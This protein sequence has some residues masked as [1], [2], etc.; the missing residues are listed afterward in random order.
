[1]QNQGNFMKA[2]ATALLVTL[3][4]F[5]GGCGTDQTEAQQEASGIWQANLSG[6][7][8]GFSFITQFTINGN[9]ALTITNFQFINNESCFPFSDG[10]NNATPAG[11]LTNLTYNAGNQIV[12]GNFSFTI[13]QNGNTLTLTST[14]VN[15]TLNGTSLNGGNIQGNWALTAGSSSG[16]SASSGIFTMTQ[17][18]SAT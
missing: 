6:T 18:S 15:G 8:S 14:S 11:Q 12:S 3:G 16:C 17:S 9:G 10:T 5:L 13:A 1:M 7:D 2:V 4:L